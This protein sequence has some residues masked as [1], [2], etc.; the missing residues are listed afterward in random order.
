MVITHL[1]WQ[2]ELIA[3]EEEADHAIMPADRCGEADRFARHAFNA[4]PEGKVVAVDSL[5]GALAGAMLAWVQGALIRAPVSGGRAQDAK[6][7]Q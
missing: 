6:R 5:G 7:L 3:I 2:P 1:H 4:S